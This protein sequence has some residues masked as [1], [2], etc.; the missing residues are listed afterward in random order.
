MLSANILELHAKTIAP[1][2]LR[3]FILEDMPARVDAFKR[4]LSEAGVEVCWATNVEAAKRLWAPPYKIALLDHDLEDADY[5]YW[6][7]AAAIDGD[8]TGYDF[9]KWL[10]KRDAGN[11]QRPLMILHS[12][13]FDGARRMT[14]GL[15]EAGFEAIQWPFANDLLEFL[16][17]VVEK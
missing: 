12:Y 9:V 11:E 14:N 1:T 17:I 5:N 13:N 2:P 3:A 15:R 16:K 7:M 6:T 10:S 8:G 4:V